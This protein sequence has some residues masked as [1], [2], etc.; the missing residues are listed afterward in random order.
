YGALSSIQYTISDQFTFSGGIDGRYY[1]GDHYREV[2]D[3]LGGS[4]YSFGGNEVFREGDRFDYDYT[5]YVRWLGVFGLLEYKQNQWTAFLNASRSTQDYRF[6]NNITGLE[7]DWVN[8]PSTTIKIG[9]NYNINN[10]HNIF[11]NAGILDKAQRY[12]NVIITNFW[13]NQSD[14]TIAENYENELI[15]AVEMGYTFRSPFFSANINAYY[16]VW[17]NKPLDRL[18]TVPEDPEN[19]DD[20]DLIPVNIPGIDALHQGIE[21][22]FAFKPTRKLD[23]QGLVSIGDWTWNSSEI[24]TV[25]LPNQIY[26]YEF[27]AQGVHVGDAA[28]IQLGA[29]VRY[30]PI[31]GFYVKLRATHFAKN[32]A[33]FQPE[34]LRGVNGGRESWQLPNYTDVSFHTGY[35]FRFDKFGLSFRANI[36]NLLDATFVTDARNNDDF[37]NPAFNDFD[38]KSASVHYGQ[39]R[40]GTFSVQVSF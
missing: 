7:I 27:D 20:S 32:Y 38:A 35:S 3:L 9:A 40:R 17:K 14:G 12:S 28:Q 10:Q 16:T 30:A 13:T 15:N 5:G 21:L 36:L 24:A 26:E 4:G 34:D 6:V 39:G 8:V 2:Y 25:T 37:N 19:P 23:I 22:D 33:D 31:R 29:S 11:V 1:K 18:P